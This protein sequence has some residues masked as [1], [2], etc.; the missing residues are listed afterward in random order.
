MTKVDSIIKLSAL[1]D[2]PEATIQ[3]IHDYSLKKYGRRAYKEALKYVLWEVAVYE[4]KNILNEKYI[5][6]LYNVGLFHYLNFDYQ[7]AIA[8]YDKNH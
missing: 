3:I 8:Y 2:P 4:D 1:T 6:A 7:N 5:N